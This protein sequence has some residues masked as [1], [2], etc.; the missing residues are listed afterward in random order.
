MQQLTID[1][2]NQESVQLF[3]IQMKQTMP[4]FVK[5]GQFISVQTDDSDFAAYFALTNLPNE[6]TSLLLK[7]EGKIATQLCNSRPGDSI[8][9]ISIEGQGFQFNDVEDRV[10]RFVSMGSGIGPIRSLIRSL[11]A[12]GPR[13]KRIE[14]WHGAFHSSDLPYKSEIKD[15]QSKGLIFYPCYDQ[16]GDQK[17][18][19][20]KLKQLAPDLTDSILF[21]VGSVDFA[22]DLSKVVFDL[23]LQ[24]QDFRTNR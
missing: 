19:V 24:Q 16:E 7:N 21:H 10:V 11:L 12:V 23:G 15:W 8:D 3:S 1:T 2:I 18:T 22:S 13:P 6:P 9:L 17:N 14:L 20:E 4:D 5:P